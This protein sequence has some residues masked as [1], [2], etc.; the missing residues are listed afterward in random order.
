MPRRTGRI[1]PNT[2]PR[3]LAVNP[4]WNLRAPAFRRDRKPSSKRADSALDIPS[5]SSTGAGSLPLGQERGHQFAE[6]VPP[7]HGRA[8]ALPVALEQP[9]AFRL[10]ELPLDP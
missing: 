4:C 9:L 2:W 8:Y 6:E 1:T 3:C 10:L 5:A 7:A